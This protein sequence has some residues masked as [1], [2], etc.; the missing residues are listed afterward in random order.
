MDAIVL[1]CKLWSAPLTSR[2]LRSAV[3]SKSIWYSHARE[4]PLTGRQISCGGMCPASTGPISCC[5]ST[6]SHGARWH[7]NHRAR[8]PLRLSQRL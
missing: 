3:A 6:I 8:L 5:P 2:C 7:G 1:P 4:Q